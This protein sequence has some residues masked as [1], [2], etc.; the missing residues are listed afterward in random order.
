MHL[1]GMKKDNE[2]I[3]E[4]TMPPFE[5][6]EENSFIMPIEIFL[7][8]VKNNIENK[9]V[10]KT[11]TIPYWLNQIA[12]QENVNF[13]QILQNGLKEYLHIEAN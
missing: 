1:W 5:D 9:A 2:N 4:P 11:L 6:I 12:E 10:K 8:I 13:S 3:P 7:D